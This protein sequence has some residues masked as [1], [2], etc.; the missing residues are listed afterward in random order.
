MSLL[1]Q[2]YQY[3]TEQ[4]YDE[5]DPILEILHTNISGLG[6]PLRSLEV[7][8][9]PSQVEFTFAAR[10]YHLAEISPEYGKHYLS[11]RVAQPDIVFERAPG[12]GIR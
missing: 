3:L 5:M 12:P 8:F 11:F 7:E 4:R 6:L 9:G 2:G 1:N 10:K